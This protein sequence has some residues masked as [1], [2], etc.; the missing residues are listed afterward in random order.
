MQATFNSVHEKLLHKLAASKANDESF[1]ERFSSVVTT[2]S[3]PLSEEQVETSFTRPDGRRVTEIVQIGKRM[4]LFKKSVEKDGAKLK[5]YWKQWEDLQN[6]F[7]ELGLEVFGKEAFSEG[8]SKD[9]K[10]EK[11]YLIEMELLDSEVNARIEEISGE[12]EDLTSMTLKALKT[13]EKVR[14]GKMCYAVI[15]TSSRK[16]INLQLMSRQ[17]TCKLL[18]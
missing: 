6:D 13:S 12:V 15:L 5:E 17:D 16:W 4:N 11:G 7:I 2:L 10:R 1:F 14:G 18:C 3:A 8:M 9:K